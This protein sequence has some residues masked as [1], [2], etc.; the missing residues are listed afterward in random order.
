MTV[1]QKNKFDDAYY[2]TPKKGSSQDTTT[3]KENTKS[4]LPSCFYAILLVNRA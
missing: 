1:N 3:I 4:F 2:V